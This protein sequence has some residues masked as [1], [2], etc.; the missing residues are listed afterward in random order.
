MSTLFGGQNTP[1]LMPNVNATNIGK[2]LQ[3]F[4]I[5]NP[6]KSLIGSLLI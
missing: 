3:P 1:R 6:F 2:K 4:F 5:I